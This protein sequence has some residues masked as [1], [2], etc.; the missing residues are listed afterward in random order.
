MI[1][2]YFKNKKFSLK[3]EIFYDKQ[4]VMT[5]RPSEISN[6]TRDHLLTLTAM[7][8]KIIWCKFGHQVGGR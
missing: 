3:I 1:L 8:T 7:Y 6:R 4:A 5:R 2:F